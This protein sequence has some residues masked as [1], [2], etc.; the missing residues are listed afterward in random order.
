MLPE[1]SVIVP[2]YNEEAVLGICYDR[3]SAVMR[4]MGRP[5][6]IIFVNDGSRD[7]TSD[8]IRSLCARDGHIQMIDLSRNFGHQ[9]AISAGFAH[10]RGKAVI[11]IDADLQDP[12][13]IIP[14][15]AAKWR[16]G[17]DVV[18]GKRVSRQGETAFKR[19][20]SKLYYRFLSRVTDVRIPVDVGDF[21]LIDRKVCDALNGLKE[22]H[23]YVRGLISW[24][25]FRQTAVEFHRAP[26]LAGVTKYPLRKMLAFA[27][28][29]IISFSSKPLKL[30]LFPGIVMSIAGF[31][32]FLWVLYLKLFAHATET[33]WASIMSAILF[34][35]G[36]TLIMLGISGEYI[37]RLFDEA[38][39]RPLFVVRE[40]IVQDGV[41]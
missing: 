30:A 37:G 11:V 4:G 25:G 5:W 32:Y 7:A 1:F 36:Y 20:T 23:R 19:L 12:P 35:N 14:D 39:G 22:Q 6:E 8:I 15:M 17:W 33:G 28:D 34:F 27:T 21:R 24:L 31:A 38:K 29:G 26:R 16:E 3:L 13:E 2:A 40:T 9:A 41:E 18:Y 10:A